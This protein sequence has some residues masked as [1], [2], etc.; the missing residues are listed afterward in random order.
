MIKC[1]N[2]T[3]GESLKMKYAHCAV[4]LRN[5]S[6]P[7]SHC[8]ILSAEAHKFVINISE[9]NLFNCWRDIGLCIFMFCLMSVYL[10]THFHKVCTLQC[11]TYYCYVLFL[12]DV[13]CVCVCLCALIHRSNCAHL[14]VCAH[15]YSCCVYLC[16][17]AY[18]SLLLYSMYEVGFLQAGQHKYLMQR[19]TDRLLE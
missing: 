9:Y 15:R 12:L 5:L 8:K 1:R 4:L 14:R 3:L 10:N 18:S 16:A 13:L 2:R 17:C 11:C 6:L 7:W 19:L